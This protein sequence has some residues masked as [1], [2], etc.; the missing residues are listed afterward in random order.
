MV[1][2]KTWKQTRE[3][4]LNHLVTDRARVDCLSLIRNMSHQIYFS[5]SFYLQ[6]QC[7]SNGRMP[8]P[9]TLF[10]PLI[11]FLLHLVFLPTAATLIWNCYVWRHKVSIIVCI[12]V[13]TW[14]NRSSPSEQEEASKSLALSTARRGVFNYSLSV[15]CWW[16]DSEG[17]NPICFTERPAVSWTVFMRP[18]AGH[19]AIKLLCCRNYRWE[20]EFFDRHSL[21]K[22]VFSENLSVLI[23]FVQ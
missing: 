13:P 7:L 6:S 11:G 22:T 14:F 15:F 20:Q 19:K 9:C 17:A 5:A 2:F 3:T 8:P 12:S 10:L 21:M 16:F 4:N 1:M 23:R 18:P